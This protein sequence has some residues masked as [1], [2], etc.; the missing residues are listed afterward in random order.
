[1]ETKIAKTEHQVIDLIKSRWS[2]RSFS[3]KAISKQNMNTLLEAASWAFSGG[4]V[5]PWKYIYAHR[6][7]SSAFEKLEHCLMPGNQPWAKNAAVLM[8]V[9]LHKKMENGNPNRTAMHD[10]GAANATMILQAESMNIYGHVMAGFDST[11]AVA[12]LG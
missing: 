8:A 1:M 12:A 10:V 6:E 4:N 9:F 11:K 2:P 3:P 7:N 5:Q